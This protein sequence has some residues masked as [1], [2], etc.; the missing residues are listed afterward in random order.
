M[1]SNYITLLNTIK[2]T[3]IYLK[4][5][6]LF[7]ENKQGIGYLKNIKLDSNLGKINLLH[8]K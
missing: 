1:Y 5:Q 3:D 4:E 7:L 6:R 8:F 2:S